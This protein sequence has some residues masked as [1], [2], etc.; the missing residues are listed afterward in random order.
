MNDLLLGCSSR[1]VIQFN[2]KDTPHNVCS[3][4]PDWRA[5]PF[6]FQRV[7]NPVARFHGPR[8]KHKPLTIET[9]L[10]LQDTSHAADKSM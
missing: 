5:V 9:L 4:P 10:K 2:D 7:A 8:K 6:F 1:E 3:R